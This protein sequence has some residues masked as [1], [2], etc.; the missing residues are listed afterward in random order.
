M[1]IVLTMNLPYVRVDGGANRM[2]RAIATR[3]V[4]AGNRVTVVAPASA[5]LEVGA[6]VGAG[7]TVLEIDGVTV[8]AVTRPGDLPG[9]LGGVLED[10]RPEAIL[11][12]S[13]DPSQRLLEVAVEHDASRTLY[14]VNGLFM[15]PFG[16]QSFYPGQRRAELVRRVGAVVTVSD[17]AKDY[18][19]RWGGVQATV[20][21]APAYPP[22]RTRG[23]IDGR[24]LM[25]NPCRGK[26]ID[27]LLG[28]ARRRPDVGFLA[29]P[30]WG[31]TEA[32]RQALAGLANIELVPP[33][34]PDALYRRASVVL[35]PSLWP[36]TFGMTVVDAMLR[37]VPVLASD[38]GALP[39]ALLGVDE[40]VPVQSIAAHEPE[41]DERLLRRAVVPPIEIDTWASRLD[42]LLEPERHADTARRA[43]AAAG[44]FV[45]GLSIAPLTEALQSLGASRPTEPT[46]EGASADT[47]SALK[48]ALVV[49]YWDRAQRPEEVATEQPER[50]EAP[51]APSQRRIWF[52]H[53]CSESGA[54]HNA[55]LAWRLTG[56]L[57]VAALR[58]AIADVVD[59]HDVLR[60]TFHHRDGQYVQRMHPIGAL[61]GATLHVCDRVS[62]ETSLFALLDA[63][64]RRRFALDRE[65]PIRVG[66]VRTAADE[67]VL[68]WVVHHIAF[69]GW[70]A[71]TM[72]HELAS[73]YDARVRKTEPTFGA[74]PPRYLDWAAA[75]VASTDAGMSPRQRAY[76]NGVV[77]RLPPASPYGSSRGSAVH[78]HR[79]SIPAAVARAARNL[80]QQE[81][82]SL[83]T[84]GLALFAAAAGVPRGITAALVVNQRRGDRDEDLVGPAFE[85]VLLPVVPAEA[86][87]FRAL[88]GQV[89]LDARAAMHNADVPFE[90][91]RAEMRATGREHAGFDLL[92]A[93]ESDSSR[94]RWSGLDVEVHPMPRHGA[95]APVTALLAETDDGIALTVE[96]RGH[97]AALGQA[98][99]E[100]ASALLHRFVDDPDERPESDRLEPP[101]MPCL[102]SLL[103][104]RVAAQPDAPAIRHGSERWSYRNLWTAAV[105]VAANLHQHGI[106]PGDV[107]VTCL[108]EGIDRLVAV[109]GV[110]VAGAAYAPIDPAT[111]TGAVA[112]MVECVRPRAVIADASTPDAWGAARVFDVHEA[113]SVPTS[114]PEAFRQSPDLA[115]VMFTSG[116]TGRPKAVSVTHRGVA[117]LAWRPAYVD[118]G[119]GRVVA[120]ASNFGF[121][122]STFEI[123]TTLLGGGE[124]VVMPARVYADPT[125]LAEFVREHGV[126]VMLVTTA[127]FNEIAEREPSAFA[128]MDQV[129]FG[130]EAVANHAVAR[131]FEHGPPRELLHAYGP[132]EA[133]T[134]A[135]V[136][137]VS[138]APSS[139]DPPVPIGRPIGETTVHVLDQSGAEVAIGVEG[140]LYLGGPGI[141][142]G[143]YRDARRTAE[144][145]CL[146]PFA[147]VEGRR[148]YR[149]GDRVVAT[150]DGLRFVGRADRQ[151]KIRGV[152]I[153]PE[154]VEILVRQ[155]PEVV[156]AA[157]LP[158]DLQTPRARLVAFV[159]VQGDGVGVSERVLEHLRGHLRGP[160]CPASIEVVDRLPLTSRGKVDHAA[161]RAAA[162]PRP[163]PVESRELDPTRN[164]IMAVFERVLAPVGGAIRRASDDFFD[165]GGHSLL[166]AEAAAQLG[167]RLGRPVSVRD[168]VEASTPD[169]LAARLG[170]A[171]VE[172]HPEPTDSA[173]VWLRRAAT[174]P[175]FV[176]LP[177]M[178]A[179][180][181][182]M[183]P[184][185][186]ALGERSVVAIEIPG[187]AD[188]SAPPASLAAF[189]ESCAQ[190]LVA[191]D[192][193]GSFVVVG[194]SFGA[195]LAVALAD[196]LQRAGR[197]VT[198]IVALDGQA[199]ADDGGPAFER[200]EPA[201]AA[202]LRLMA[203]R[204]G[205]SSVPSVSDP[206]S[207]HTVLV[208]W[209]MADPADEGRTG[210]WIETLRVCR[211]MRC[212]APARRIAPVSLITAETR[213]R[214]AP[215]D[216]SWGWRRWST[217]PVAVLASP[218]DHF[219]MLEPSHAASLAD[220]VIAAVESP[221]SDESNPMNEPL[222]DHC[223]V[224][225]FETHAARAP[226][227][228]AIRCEEHA[229][230]YGELSE[231]AQA[232]G[233]LL[234]AAGVG[235]ETKV[236]VSLPR[237]IACIVAML[238]VLRAGGAYVPVDPDY[239]ASRIAFI[240]RDS[241]AS[242]TI[243]EAGSTATEPGLPRLTLGPDGR[244]VDTPPPSTAPV[245]DPS[246]PGRLAYLIYT[247]GTTGQPKGVLVEHRHVVRLVLH[248]RLLFDLGPDDVWLQYHSPSFDFSVW[249]IFGALL[250]GGSVVI[251]PKSQTTAPAEVLE[252]IDR[253]GV[254]VLSQTPTAFGALSGRAL[255]RDELPPRLRLVVFGGERLEPA[256]L[257]PW[258][259]RFGDARPALVNMF[260]IT[261][262]TVHTT[263]KIL[264]GSDFDDDAPSNIGVPWP[265]VAVDLVDADGRVV[266]EG[267]ML[268]GGAGVARGYHRRPEQNAARFVVR[269]DEHGEASRWYRSGDRARRLPNGDLVYLGRIDA[270]LS[271]RGFRIEPAEVES[272]LGDHEAVTAAAVTT[273]D[274]GEGDV[275]LIAYVVAAGTISETDLV[276]SI[277]AHLRHRLPAH[278][279]P[280]RISM[281]EALPMTA[282]GKLDREVLGR[283]SGA[284]ASAQPVGVD[285]AVLSLA[286][287]II[288]D[289]ALTMDE[290]LFDAGA[291]SLSII[292]LL[293]QVHANHRVEIG[294]RDL[295]DDVSVA[296]IV[297]VIESRQSCSPPRR[298]VVP[299]IPME[300][301]A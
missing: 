222:F 300:S 90:S 199:P 88:L 186:R 290:D 180:A 225:H 97:E 150:P 185:G 82:V 261:E 36:E 176:L 107:V 3:L 284:P 40:P 98:L 125:A 297:A 128:S 14:Y 33:Q 283:R 232:V 18:L 22:A 251:L 281:V 291:T 26:G 263:Y 146:D 276:A 145:F 133:T 200:D 69:D 91:V 193:C 152:R 137:R 17:F 214:A 112:A 299:T 158:F 207:V 223:I 149:T 226:D 220:Q 95:K 126:D 294:P 81:R 74:D 50:T 285:T 30:S 155:C 260:G 122:A 265:D 241:G 163:L 239:P 83:H 154:A 160:S 295:Q 151:V 147:A 183:G 264:R 192:T 70:S 10:E 4:D 84:L 245:G 178:L 123:W 161:L 268:V 24:V 248:A 120:Q 64:A 71:M 181:A 277:R 119:P 76:W 256:R 230:T 172:V 267:E 5:Q 65:S 168:I 196:R 75:R 19:A 175:T 42:A 254:T 23:S 85:T 47:V 229:L 255:E 61:P 253:H 166:V 39:E 191:D 21:R 204:D 49:A 287:R 2:M 55:S 275:R 46:S 228:V 94:V 102:R 282:H 140:E 188:G 221:V 249:E 59:R 86:P 270:Q 233:D 202:L 6:G 111:P 258:V 269:E 11:V 57:D 189:I 143:Y 298:S 210:R 243:D 131:I 114:A 272:V 211:A 153:E 174:G 250:T 148:M 227:R 167:E 273:E 1:R 89:H 101:P 25:I 171:A 37:G 58:Q 9:H 124:L 93:H 67:H 142:R 43:E 247:S 127:V 224:H 292:R 209:G 164:A 162:S 130:G 286:R 141:A 51:L 109:V 45:E 106:G 182:M 205:R 63:E 215:D 195:V 289:D 219:T 216:A 144:R 301:R 242:V 38:A 259:A 54:D 201:G 27:V 108:S 16:P 29:V 52:E 12:T 238:G 92:F 96:T 231:R 236:I 60:C 134:L 110:I 34:D 240:V 246:D 274:H 266:P 208:E 99:V 213:R 234:R 15:L 179:T 79:R 296:R 203:A 170:A 13:E 169:R 206:A 77:E 139:D 190:D 44:R 138:A 156:D 117:N 278:L 279:R 173:L 288:G 157:V 118:T 104:R 177:G 115:C 212:A 80:A 293:A 72:L 252:A 217:T 218:G 271:V 53:E 100:R 136:H 244:V 132:S 198:R 48:R 62:S 257:R 121:D 280:A 116:S 103:E 159:T 235:P 87:S 32:D 187:V 262:T 135:T 35:V 66:V 31:T 129:L 56:R 73:A 41:F 105:R 237:G 194:H 68:W 7:A 197:R 78:R 8:H 28:L 184:L 113:P 20:F 165:C